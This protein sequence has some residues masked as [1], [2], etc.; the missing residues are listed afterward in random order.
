MTPLHTSVE[1]QFDIVQLEADVHVDALLVEKVDEAPTGEL[2]GHVLQVFAVLAVDP[3]K[4]Y[5]AL[6]C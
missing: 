1:S 3:P 5:E 6:A 4:S 2:T